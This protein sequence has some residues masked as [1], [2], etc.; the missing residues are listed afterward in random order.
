MKTVKK[1]LSFFG[2]SFLLLVYIDSLSQSKS[3]L[4]KEYKNAKENVTKISQFNS[5]IQ[6]DLYQSMDLIPRIVWGKLE[7]KFIAKKKCTLNGKPYL[8]R[9][10]DYDGDGLAD[11]FAFQTLEGKDLKDDFGFM[12]DTNKDGKTDYIIFN[13]GLMMGIN[14]DFYYFFYHW[15]DTDFDGKIDV[16]A[17]NVFIFPGDSLPDPKII[18]WVL[19]TD[20]DDKPDSVD[21]LNIQNGNKN[22]L[23]ASDGI[24]TY[25]TI[26]GP[27]V[28]NSNDENYFKKY[29]EYLK[30]LNE[31]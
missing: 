31:E 16:I 18:L 5:D 26:F 2:F 14:N 11:Q 4:I 30:A 29:T 13:G 3:D 24:W 7:R 19:D 15:I 10:Y 8:I 9:F 28:V 12:Y 25:N 6:K 27:Y 17:S 20:K 21:C 23:K 22:S 1:Y